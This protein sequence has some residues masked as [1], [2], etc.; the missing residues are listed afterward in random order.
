MNRLLPPSIRVWRVEEVAPDFH[1]RFSARSKLY[2]YRLWRGEVCDPMV[3]RYVYHH[4]YPLDVAAMVEAAPLLE[5]TH[6]F[7]SLAAADE[8]ASARQ[9]KVRTILCSRLETEG[10]L[11][12][13]RIRGTG[14]LRHMVRNIMGTLLE[15][16]K[17]NLTPADIERIL[18]AGDR[19]HAGPTAAARGLFLVE[20]E[21]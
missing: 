1:A 17:G 9:D 16:G 15:V 21:Y 2:E 5:G 18:R 6:D 19:R 7:S 14:F 8:D 4:P 13:Y 12:R 20:V 3:Y 10:D 11:V